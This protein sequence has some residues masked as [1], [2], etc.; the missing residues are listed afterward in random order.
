MVS[1][2]W[3]FKNF[4]K[5]CDLGCSSHMSTFV[6]TSKIRKRHLEN[7]FKICFQNHGKSLRKSWIN[8]IESLPQFC[9]YFFHSSVLI[10]TYLAPI[11]DHFSSFSPQICSRIGPDAL[12]WLPLGSSWPHLGHL[13][14]PLGPTLAPL[15]LPFAMP[16][17]LLTP[18][19]VI[20]SPQVWF[21]KDFSSIFCVF[22]TK[23]CYFLYHFY[24][25]SLK[26]SCRYL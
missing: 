5:S 26:V 22:Q 8:V 11:S 6:E 21:W 12:F 20:L 9:R 4:P 16:R 14:D 2:F 17:H 3:F 23:S 7:P 15:G 13:L 10:F 24:I 19:L 25:L 1:K 18:I